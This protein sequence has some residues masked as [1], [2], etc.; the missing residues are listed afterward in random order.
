MMSTRKTY[1]SRLADGTVLCTTPNILEL[2][3]TAQGE[4][5]VTF[6]LITTRSF[7][8]ED[9]ATA[10]PFDPYSTEYELLAQEAAAAVK[11]APKL[12][13]VVRYR[14]GELRDVAHKV[15]GINYRDETC[16]VSLT[17]ETDQAIRWEGSWAEFND[18]FEKTGITARGD[19]DAE[20]VPC[21][22]DWIR[23]GGDC[24]RTP[25]R[26]GIAG[27]GHEH[28]TVGNTNAER[29]QMMALLADIAERRRQA[30]RAGDGQGLDTRA[31]LNL[32][33][34]GT[35]E[36]DIGT[37]HE[38]RRML[39]DFSQA[40]LDLHVEVWAEFKTGLRCSVCGRTAKQSDA[41]G[42]DCAREC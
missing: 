20:W 19:E 39:D 12:D 1:E 25:R 8:G 29:Q 7:F 36:H 30:Y 27:I 10:E 38:A 34:E 14:T 40:V 5:G 6:F 41:I 11:G 21:T 2:R 33:A 15:T 26:V 22:P 42:Y 17:R 35:T 9:T 32:R 16:H 4:R 3:E 31:H 18:M 28:R 24:D 13:E 23:A 37:L